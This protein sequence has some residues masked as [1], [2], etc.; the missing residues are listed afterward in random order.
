MNTDGLE[1]GQFWIEAIWIWTVYQFKTVPIQNCFNSNP[2]QFRTAWCQNCPSSRP[3]E[4]KVVRFKTV[5]IQNWPYSKL[6]QFKIVPNS[7]PADPTALRRES[8]VQIWN[9]NQMLR[10]NFWLGWIFILEYQN[11]VSFLLNAKPECKRPQK[12]QKIQKR[13]LM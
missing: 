13:D 11:H 5:P 12:I 4:F 6:F 2:A 7:W 8:L 1:R 3:S 10:V 9:E